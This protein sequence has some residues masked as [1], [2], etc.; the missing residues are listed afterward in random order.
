M[1]LIKNVLD[2]T[3]ITATAGIG[4]NMFLAKVAMDV[5]AKH[6][7][8]DK[9]GV[10]IAEL[11]VM[12]FRRTLWSHRPITDI[13]RIGPGISRRLEKMGIFT[14]GDIALC[15]VRNEERLYKEFGVNAELMINHA[16]GY[17]PTTIADVKAFRPENNSISS[18]QVLSKPYTWEKGRLILREMTDLL[19]LDLVD[20]RLVT[21]QMV[22]TVGYDTEN[23]S[24]DYDG[25]VETDRYGRK[26]PKNAHGSINLGEYTSSTKLIMEKA[27]ELYERIT[28]KSLTVRRMYVVANHVIPESE[29]P[30]KSGTAQLS[31]FDD[32]DETEKK[33]AEKEAAREKERRIQQAAIEL[34]KKFGKNAI[35][36]GINLQEGATTIERNKQVGG[37]KDGT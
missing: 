22:L 3:G 32:P 19:V 23:V 12:S 31:L 4:T 11:D 1:R 14:L 17:E 25:A 33:E 2:E 7:P 34:K 15:S 30:A 16:W 35:L 21:D 6:M 9:D 36:K 37:H 8:A 18:G 13:W 29:A 27:T 20:K 10:R 28:D 5:S 24:G 26:T